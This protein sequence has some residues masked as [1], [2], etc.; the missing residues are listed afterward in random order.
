MNR[1]RSLLSMHCMLLGY[2][3]EPRPYIRALGTVGSVMII[4]S[5]VN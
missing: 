4:G 5:S 3:F 1:V 2:R